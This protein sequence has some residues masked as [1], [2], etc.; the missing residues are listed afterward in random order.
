MPLVTPQFGPAFPY[1]VGMLL[2]GGIQNG[3]QIY[4]Q[5]G[6][7]GT[8]V[9]PQP[10]Q[11]NPPPNWHGANWLPQ[12]PYAY[13]ALLTWGCAHWTNTA[14]VFRGFNPYD[15]ESVAFLCCPVCGYLGYIVEPYEDW[16][17]EFYSIF[18]VGVVQPG[19]PIYS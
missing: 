7:I 15:Q 14:E 16:E 5:P 19:Y 18:P 12:F 13:T 9:F 10:P 4:T 11:I 17:R 6:G 3:Q 1:Q 2:F 8:P